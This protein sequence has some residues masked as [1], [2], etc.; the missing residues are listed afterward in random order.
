MKYEE[1]LI[2]G[3]WTG[4]S[5][6]L[7]S[8]TPRRLYTPLGMKSVLTRCGEVFVARSTERVMHEK[9]HPHGSVADVTRFCKLPLIKAL[10]VSPDYREVRDALYAQNIRHECAVRGTEKGADYCGDWNDVAHKSFLMQTSHW[11]MFYAETHLM[12]NMM[13]KWSSSLFIPATGF[14]HQICPIT[15]K[16]EIRSSGTKT[17]LTDAIRKILKLIAQFIAVLVRKTPCISRPWMSMNAY[18]H[19]VLCIGDALSQG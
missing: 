9:V 18:Y 19:N 12:V 7:S 2:S 5:R 10:R 1:Y 8:A 4:G 16:L 15:H 3:L 11:A 14:I 6:D 17:K 13:V